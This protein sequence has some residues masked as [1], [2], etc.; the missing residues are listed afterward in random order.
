MAFGRGKC[1]V[2]ETVYSM[3]GD[4]SPPLAERI[5]QAG[6]VS[7]EASATEGLHR[8]LLSLSCA[9]PVSA[10]KRFNSD[11]QNSRLINRK[12]PETKNVSPD[13][14]KISERL[15]ATTQ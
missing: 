11:Q 6:F 9:L 4:P 1:R 8:K 7:P 10:E 5:I 3:P 13:Q 14:P 12:E 2:G 15:V